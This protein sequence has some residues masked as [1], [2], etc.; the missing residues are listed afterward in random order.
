MSSN[1]SEDALLGGRVKLLQ[2]RDGFRAAL[3]PVLL[4]AFVPARP[5]DS[6]LE[7]GCGTGAAFLC[8]AARVPRLGILAVDRDPALVDIAQRNAGLNLLP[9]EIRAADARELR[10]LPPIHHAFANPPYWAGGT[11]S[12]MAERRQAAHEDAPLLDWVQAMARPL[13]HK[14]TLSL[15]LPAARFAEA[16]AALIEAGCGAVRLLPLWPRQGVPA[17]RILIQARRGGAGPD[18]VLPGLVLHEADGRYTPA[19][20]AVLREASALT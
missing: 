10:H 1:L 3:D 5:G 13:R 16:A 18:E 15:V 11:P 19:A 9:A 7:L 6:V 20:E 2:P 17:K 12:P 14:G 8:L 4:A